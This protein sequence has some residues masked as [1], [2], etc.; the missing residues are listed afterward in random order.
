MIGSVGLQFQPR[1]FTSWVGSGV[2]ATPPLVPAVP[3]PL[4][5][6]L[7]VFPPPPGLPLLPA[8]P[9]SLL[10]GDA[11]PQKSGSNR[12]TRSDTRGAESSS[13]KSS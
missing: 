6:A 12:T 5:P 3:E 4:D 7:P 10:F 13:H 8:P 11:Q 9:V 1:S 2:Q